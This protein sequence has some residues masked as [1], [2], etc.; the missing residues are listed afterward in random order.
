MVSFHEALNNM[1]YCWPFTPPI[2]LVAT[3]QITAYGIHNHHMC[4][5]CSTEDQLTKQQ[6]RAYGTE[7][8]IQLSG[9]SS[10][11]SSLKTLDIC[12]LVMCEKTAHFRVAFCPQHKVHL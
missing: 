4:T 10:G 6:C 9:N 11:G 5:Y 8:N 1:E 7:I 12:G 3:M 2:P